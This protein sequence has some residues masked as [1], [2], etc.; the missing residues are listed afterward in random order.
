[1]VVDPPSRH[2]QCR[3]QSQ[4]LEIR[5][6][7][8]RI[9]VRTRV[10]KL[11]RA[12]PAFVDRILSVVQISTARSLFGHM[13]RI[14]SPRG[15]CVNV[16]DRGSAKTSIRWNRRA[17]A[18]RQRASCSSPALTL[19][20]SS[21][22]SSNSAGNSSWHAKCKLEN[23]NMNSLQRYV[24]AL[25]RV[26]MSIVFLLNGFGIINQ[27]VAAKELIEHGA[28]ASVVPFLMLIARTIE[29][30]AGFSLALGIYPR[31]AAVAILAFLF[32]A[33]LTAHA[34]WQVSG[35]AGFTL[36]LLNFS[37][38]IAMMGG[39]LFIAAT[40]SQPTLLSRTSLTTLQNEQ[41][42]RWTSRSSARA[43]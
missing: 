18:D 27:T 1:M 22:T 2:R 14:G 28:P 15:Y 17:L 30:V 13:K 36:Q 5:P 12:M 29:I 7:S 16:A 11:R 9:S 8:A 10:E 40:R 26:L 31:L 39:L 21:S 34:F 19:L 3:T 42:M 20:W 6:R 43:S 32:P 25:S 41:D 37:K 23:M 35:T 4:R 24:L 33:T 38:N